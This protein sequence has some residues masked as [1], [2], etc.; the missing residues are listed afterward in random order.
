MRLLTVFSGTFVISGDFPERE[1]RDLTHQEDLS[2]LVG[3]LSTARAMRSEPRCPRLAL[4]A[5]AR[6]RRL[7]TQGRAVSS[8]PRDSSRWMLAER[9]LPQLV[10]AEVAG[11]RVHPRREPGLV[12]EVRRVLDDATKASWTMSSASGW[13]APAGT[14][15]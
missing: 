3:S 9:A 10:D 5:R 6:I 8:S 11:D 15:S 14:Q 7:L 4:H 13:T 12:L 2:L 1:V